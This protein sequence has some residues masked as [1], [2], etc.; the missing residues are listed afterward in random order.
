M[1]K[2]TNIYFK[3]F[4]KHDFLASIVVFLV[5]IPL[6]L[7]V[8]LAAGAP[9]Y[10]GL[11]SGIAGGMIVGIL[12]RS[13]LSVSGPSAAIVAI[14]ISALSQ[15][16][17][18][19][20]V[21][22]AIFLAGFL[23]VLAGYKKCG[24]FADYIPNNV[25]QG[26]L[27]AIGL[28][29][30]IKQ[31][32]LAFTITKNFGELQEVLVD[33][34]EG[35]GFHPLMSLT[36]HINSGGVIL[37]LLSLGIML[38]VEK[39]KSTLLQ[40][41]PG[42]IIVVILGSLINLWFIDHK[43]IFAQ[44]VPLLVNIPQYDSL[45]HIWHTLAKPDWS[46]WLNPNVYLY[47]GLI[48]AVIS[49][50]TLMNISATEKVDPR[51]QTID[52]DRELLAQGVGNMA[53]AIFGGIPLSSVI[54]RTSV[55]IQSKAKTKVSTIVH[56]L[57]LLLS[58]CF[59][60]HILNQ[61]P[62]CI[63][64]S[65]LIFTGYK[66]TKPKIYQTMYQQG[67]NRFLPFI[68]TL[69][70]IVCFNLLLGIIVGLIT[71]L[72]FILRSGSQV[73]IDIIQEVYPT[74]ITNRL[75]LPQQTTFLN[76]ASLIAELNTIPK[77]SQ[78]IIDARFTEF[79]DKEIIEFIQEFKEE[80]APQKNI[81]LNLIG[82]KDHYAIHDHINFINVTTYDAQSILTPEDV[83]DILKQGNQRFL[84]D[85]IIHRSNMMDI[86]HT[87]KTQHPIA[88]VLGCIDSRVPVETIF[89]M[90][91]G[92]LFC[93]RI[94]GN[95]VNDDI[96]ASIEYACH[97]VGAKLIVVLGHTG[98]GAI[99]AACHDFKEGHITQLLHKIKPAIHVQEQHSKTIN[100]KFID[101]VTHLNI[102]NSITE[103][104]H[105]STILNQLLQSEK[106]GIVGAVYDVNS[107]KVQFSNYEK[108][109]QVFNKEIP[110]V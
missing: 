57:F 16:Q 52:K 35:F 86:Q 9:I 4:F 94:A 27:S 79:M 21:L 90:T 38:Y 103:I 46:Q 37:S 43:S 64:S 48:A 24:F 41:F 60:P 88:V 108:E 77:D 71:H 97:V 40:F 66:L 89:D 49:L 110:S 105:K 58:F 65:I 18:Y 54:V 59:I 74:G 32:P 72:F 61:I 80:Q 47:A 99:N 34:A 78:L 19:E 51:H 26:M 8:A 31:I 85:Q 84:K 102:A 75:V 91:F 29:L 7:G 100:Q 45:A 14:I 44:H 70:G 6:C 98:C 109:L 10:S 81:S 50:E 22:L 39:S 13:Q 11:I 25:I 101:N 83:L 93:I 56:G 33:S 96:L 73:R 67:M 42:A 15:L 1:I 23:Q 63:L 106:I 69:L 62:L 5:A 20:S 87:A 82:F 12:S 17:H 28:L 55:N 2:K 3:R 76:K 68:V 107:G 104:T 30:I 36:F 95:V 53:A 92:D